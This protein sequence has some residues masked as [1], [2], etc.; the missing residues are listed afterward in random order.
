VAHFVRRIVQAMVL[1]DLFASV[2]DDRPMRES[3]PAQ[4]QAR[5]VSG[6]MRAPPPLLLLPPRMTVIL[7]EARR[8]VAS[9]H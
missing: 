4:V 8:L 7:R 5:R 6:P 3:K 2:L 1:D 9:L